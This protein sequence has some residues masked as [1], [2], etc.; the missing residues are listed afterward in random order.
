MKT[1]LFILII[2]FVNSAFS[3]EVY[4]QNTYFGILSNLFINH[5]PNARSEALGRG[6]V[7]GNDGNFGSY[8]N[9]ALTSLS[10]GFN[11][12]FSYSESRNAKPSI[13][14]Y[15]I[16]YSGEKL[17]SFGIS[18]NIFSKRELN[19]YGFKAQNRWKSYYDAI[20]NI[21]YSRE[22]VKDFFAGVNLGI[23][24]F[25]NYYEW[26]IPSGYMGNF[27]IDDGLYL[28][29][30]VLKRFMVK[31][32]DFEHIFQLAAACN[33]ITDSKII[34][35]DIGYE[36]REPIPVILKVGGSYQFALLNGQDRHKIISTFTQIEFEKTVNSELSHT[37]KFGQELTIYEVLS[38]RL[39][40]FSSPQGGSDYD[41]SK[42]FT[43]GLGVNVPLNKILKTKKP[44]NIK[45]D[46]AGTD[47]DKVNRYGFVYDY[48]DNYR[49]INLSVNFSPY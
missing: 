34:T 35:T 8:Y 14:A 37:L 9:P 41:D 5:Q 20:Y 26:I 7:A 48:Y 2:L 19:T 11:F 40:Y 27:V 28:D 1:I 16:F 39:G 29:A 22:V 30:G 4:E 45:L 23:F 46:Y 15:N 13:T 21:N 18:A 3:Q 24:H 33:N 36:E 38:L 32:S 17:G 47:L 31:H 6:L 10:K 12:N 42:K 44:L 25:H 49:I 43:Y